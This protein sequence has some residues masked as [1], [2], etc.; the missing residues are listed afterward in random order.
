M[1]HF[2]PQCLSFM[3][4]GEFHH[5]LHETDAVI[6]NK[7]IKDKKEQNKK[8]EQYCCFFTLSDFTFVYNLSH[9]FY[10]TDTPR[11]PISTVGCEAKLLTAYVHDTKILVFFPVR[12]THSVASPYCTSKFNNN[13]DVIF[14]HLRQ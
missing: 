8:K 12:L 11:Q 1:S 4:N 2:I 14:N 6:K 10:F 5:C 7:N 3:Q 13:Y 9:Y